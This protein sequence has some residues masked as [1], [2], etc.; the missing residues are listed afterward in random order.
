MSLRPGK[1]RPAGPRGTPERLSPKSLRRADADVL[2]TIDDALRSAARAAGANLVCRPSC[3]ECCY[4]PFPINRL[5]AWR[6]REGLQALRARD[7]E[8]AAAI[9]ERARR[10]IESFRAEFPGDGA[11][12][13]LAGDEEAEDRFF[14]QHAG[15]PCPVL[16]PKT[17]TCDLYEHRPV[18]CRT[19]GPPVR[20]GGEDL[21]PCRLCFQ[22]ATTET[23]ESC[24]V[25]PDPQRL[26]RAVVARLERD[27]GD[28][29][30]TLIAYAVKDE[31]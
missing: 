27:D 9:E 16:D 15:V 14:E 10:T 31:G 3:S 30:E 17:Q 5:D 18:S 12:G 13:R 19:Y 22:G 28:A 2:G 7:P 11:T 25:E 1:A 8:R 20:F 21:P 23:I 29:G 26:E 24:R 4:G 6:L